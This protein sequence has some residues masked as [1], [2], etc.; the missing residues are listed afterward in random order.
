MQVA[1]KQLPARTVFKDGYHAKQV[2]R[3]ITLLKQVRMASDP[4][5]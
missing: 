2:Y 1:I 5:R 4:T 3:E